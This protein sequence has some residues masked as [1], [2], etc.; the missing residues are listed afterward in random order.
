MHN[1]HEHSIQST[2]LEP[3]QSHQNPPMMLTNTYCPP[4]PTRTQLEKYLKEITR[5]HAD[6]THYV[7][8]MLGDAKAQT[9]QPPRV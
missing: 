5:N 6:K 8:M 2:K 4:E 1:N 7:D 3:I 9:T